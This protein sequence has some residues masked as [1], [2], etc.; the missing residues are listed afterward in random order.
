MSFVYIQLNS[1]IAI[2]ADDGTGNNSF[3]EDR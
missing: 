3:V 2:G 1:D